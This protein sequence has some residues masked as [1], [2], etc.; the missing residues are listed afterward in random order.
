MQWTLTERWNVRALRPRDPTAKTGEEGSA[1]GTEEYGI[2]KHT[3]LMVRKCKWTVP[4]FPLF[5]QVRHHH[6]GSLPAEATLDPRTPLKTGL[7]KATTNPEKNTKPIHHFQARAR[8]ARGEDIGE[9][10]RRTA[11]CWI[12]TRLGCSTQKATHSSCLL[13][14]AR[15]PQPAGSSPGLQKVTTVLLC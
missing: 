12:P 4:L 11:R 13:T 9:K 6:R 10:P 8:D 7:Q 5:H 1:Q 15:T 2:K 3:A 14:T